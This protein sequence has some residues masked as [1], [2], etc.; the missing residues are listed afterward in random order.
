MLEF[1]L[2]ADVRR[3]VLSSIAASTRI[4]SSIL[5]QMQDSKD[6]VCQSRIPD[7]H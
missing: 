6:S 5:Q 2:N 1:D 7:D 3:A 4:L